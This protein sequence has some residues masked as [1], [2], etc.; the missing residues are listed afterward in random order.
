MVDIIAGEGLQ[1]LSYMCNSFTYICI[2]VCYYLTN[3]P[4]LSHFLLLKYKHIKVWISQPENASEWVDCSDRF[5][6][7]EV[8]RRPLHIMRLGNLYCLC[9][10]CLSLKDN[11]DS[12]KEGSKGQ[13]FS[14]AGCSPV[15]SESP[16][17][18]RS[19]LA[20]INGQLQE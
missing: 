1:M 13:S 16:N 9:N 14:G 19:M 3:E 11:G 20:T 10:S 18:W 12:V 7:Y 4:A 6:Q 5:I 15:S 17:V 8:Y 2:T